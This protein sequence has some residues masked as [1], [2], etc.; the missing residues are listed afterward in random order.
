[1]EKDFLKDFVFQI[2]KQQEQKDAEEKRKKYF[3]NIGRKGG[4]KKKTSQQ[5]SKVVSV[6][7]TEKEFE[8]IE[9]QASKYNLK[10]SKYLRLLLTEKELK[11][12]EFKTDEVLLEYGNHFIRI[13]NLLRLREFSEFENKKQILHEIEAVTNLIYQYLYEKQ[14]KQ[15]HT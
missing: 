7:L 13:K 14:N 15:N 9:K 2:S 12:N 10:I 8:E 1:M 4:L 5:F 6:R 11:I 3:Q